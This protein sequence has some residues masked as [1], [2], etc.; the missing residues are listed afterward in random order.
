[1]HLPS[2]VWG[3]SK[4]F[5]VMTWTQTH[6]FLRWRRRGNCRKLHCL[7]AAVFR[8]VNSRLEA[9]ADAAEHSTGTLCPWR[10]LFRGGWEMFVLLEWDLD[11]ATTGQLQVPHGFSV[12]TRPQKLIAPCGYTQP[13]CP[14][15]GLL[16]FKVLLK[17]I[18]QRFQMLLAA[19]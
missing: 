14:W 7:N 18:L 5:W 15:P 12:N 4:T 10:V 6:G 11:P 17:G 2:L 1:M 19:W 9:E 3:W 13:A 16:I 8:E